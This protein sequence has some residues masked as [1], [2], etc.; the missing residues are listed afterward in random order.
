MSARPELPFGLEPTAKPQRELFDAEL[1]IDRDGPHQFEIGIPMRD[2]VE[3]AALVHL[4]AADQRPAPA[5]VHGT[6][7][8]K[9]EHEQEGVQRRIDA[10]YALVFYD[11]RGRGSSEGEWQPLSMVDAFDG[12]D[13]VEWVAAQEW[14]SGAVGAEGLSYDGWITMATVSQQPP[15]LKAAIP[16]SPAG[17]WQEEI[18]YQHGCFQLFFVWWWAM[19]RRRIMEQPDAAPEL[20]E[21]L[22]IEAAGE[23]INPA[24]PGWRE[25]M[26]HETL[27]ELWRARRWDGECSFDV[28]CLHVTGWHDRE[29]LTG[30]FHHYEEMIASSPA[31][32]RQWLLVGPWTHVSTR[33]PSDTYAGVTYPDAALDM[34]AI[35]LRFFDHF[36]KGVD[37]GVEEEPRVRIYDPGA[38]QWKVRPAWEGGTREQEI[39][40]GAGGRLLEEAGPDGE[41]VYRYDP[42]KPNGM[43]YPTDV[44]PLEPPLDLSE[45]ESQ[46]GV[47]GWTGEPLAEDVTVRGWGEL[48]LWA[49]T[50]REDTE[51]YVKLADVGPDGPP[52]WVA[53]G[54]LRAS[55]GEDPREPAAVTPGERRRYRVELTP[56]F[57]T[58]RA[59]HRFRVLL[60][61]SE[62]PWFARNMNR[63]EPIGRQH[64][65]LVATNTVFHG[66]GAPSRLRLRVE[67]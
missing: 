58:F 59:G 5:I 3:L 28:P 43:K 34:T 53:W 24:G 38:G 62:Y 15:H 35:E 29:D 26:E 40:L 13:A 67:E 16:F 47:V 32:D 6:P 19:V 2:G 33:W 39:F 57:H 10:G 64:E 66:D 51:W 1:A 27:D 12:H 21:L 44:L 55:F 7:Y 9:L 56:T 31:R 54:C 63:F 65:P 37:N 61:S 22:P 17:R 14:C 36:L 20:L 8:G 50:D 45:F 25:F 52:L 49:A 11:T 48:E 18:P 4:P 60:S 41:D 30:A 46:D 42:M 23:R